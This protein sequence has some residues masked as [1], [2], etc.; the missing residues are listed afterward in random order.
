MR[1]K[2]ISCFLSL[3]LIASATVPCAGQAKEARSTM[4]VERIKARIA[5][6]HA[7]DKRLIVTLSNGETMSGTV[8]PV[9]DVS[10]SI[11]RNHGIFGE[12]ETT[13][14]NYADVVSVR[15]RNPLVKA[16]KA[17]GSA[18]LVAA[19]V[20]AILPLWLSLEGL[21]FLLHGEGLPSC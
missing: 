20:A 5:E 4:T 3:L 13:L 21:S 7:R 6:A 17:I 16:L 1:S 18:S 14:M 2:A 8:A 15:G 9:S 19:G 11:T 10:F 12:G